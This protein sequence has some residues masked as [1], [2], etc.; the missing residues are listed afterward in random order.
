MPKGKAASKELVV[1]DRLE[2]GITESLC[3]PQE[4]TLQ[5]V[6]QPSVVVPAVLS[7]GPIDSAGVDNIADL[8]MRQ[9][10]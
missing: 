7:L 1:R 9:R 10:V 5:S 6:K 3:V 2:V 8:S 4:V